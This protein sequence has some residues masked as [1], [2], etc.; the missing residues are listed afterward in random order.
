MLGTIIGD[1]IGSRFEFENYRTGEITL[2]TEE[3]SFT[4]DSICTAATMEWILNGDPFTPYE[5]FLRAWG[6]RYPNPMGGYGERFGAWLFSDEPKPYGSYGN[7]S[8]MRVSPVAAVYPRTPFFIRNIMELARETAECTHNHRE[9]I[10][11]AQAVALA[12]HLFYCGRSKAQVKES[13]ENIFGYVMTGSIAEI[14]AAYSFN[15]TCQGTVPQALQWVFLADSFTEA[16]ENGITIGGDTDT[17][18]AIAGGI[19]EAAFTIPD[20]VIKQAVRFMPEDILTTVK[21]FFRTFK[22]NDHYLEILSK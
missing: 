7:G 9:G 8:A 6:R 10:K 15:E 13:I 16:M 22:V 20:D 14:R 3:C 21:D 11:G 5:K 4:D 1:I 19:A 17:I 18:C 12:I 2:F